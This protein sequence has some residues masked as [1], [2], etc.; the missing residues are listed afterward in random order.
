MSLRMGTF[1][2]ESSLLQKG[3]EMGAEIKSNTEK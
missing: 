3:I 1:S 2:L